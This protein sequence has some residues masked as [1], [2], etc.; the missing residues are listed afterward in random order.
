MEFFGKVRLNIGNSILRKR[1]SRISRKVI[2]DGFAGIKK[3]GLVWDAVNPD[4]FQQISKFHQKMSERGIETSVFA[5]YAGKELPD[6]L[7]AIRFLTCLRKKDLNLYYIPVSGEAEEFIRKKFD[8][9]IDLNFE[10]TFPLKY[11][12][13]LSASNFKVGIYNS[14]QGMR[15]YDLMMELKRPF[16][17]EYYL[18]E[19]L[20]YLEMI[21]PGSK[22][23]SK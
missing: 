16:T 8:V 4:D 3:I 22:A 12:T 23:N 1:A 20:N 10:E 2:Y 14:T 9:L 6:K 7:T 13:V 11:I 19:V 21:N 18:T 15:S 17:I 5:F